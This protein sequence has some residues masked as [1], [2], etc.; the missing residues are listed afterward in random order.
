LNE[1]KGRKEAIKDQKLI[2]RE[3]LTDGTIETLLDGMHIVFSSSDE[4][5]NYLRIASRGKENSLVFSVNWSSLQSLSDHFFNAHLRR[6]DIVCRDTPLRNILWRRFKRALQLSIE[7]GETA[8]SELSMFAFRS[9]ESAV[10][11]CWRSPA[12]SSKNPRT[13]E[14][15]QSWC[16]RRSGQWNQQQC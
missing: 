12:Q 6:A 1:L 4:Y 10:F 8:A 13:D 2:K 16:S 9:E 14:T 3:A 15:N 5:F 7:Q 11:T